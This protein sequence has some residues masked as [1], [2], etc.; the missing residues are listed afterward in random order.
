MR[1][2]GEP[3]RW[4]LICK[5]DYPE[6][7]PYVALEAAGNVQDFYSGP[8][9]LRWC[10]IE[11]ALNDPDLRP[12]VDAWDAGDDSAH[13]EEEARF[14]VEM[15]ADEV[16]ERAEFISRGLVEIEATDPSGV[17]EASDRWG[18]PW[19]R[20]WVDPQTADELEAEGIAR[21]VFDVAEP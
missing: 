1:M 9:E 5:R 16:L 17:I 19:L 21:R 10:T 4:L 2:E 3:M 12:L 11:E 7:R 14:A 20:R 8:C 13:A 15:E 18:I 6:S